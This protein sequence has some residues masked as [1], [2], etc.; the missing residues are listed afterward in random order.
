MDGGGA[1]IG[2]TAMAAARYLHLFG[3]ASVG[4]GVSCSSKKPGWA[5]VMSWAVRR[6]V[7]RTISANTASTVPARKRNRGV[8]ASTHPTAAG[9]NHLRGESDKL[10]LAYG[11]RR[12]AHRGA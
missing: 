5:L 12:D 4:R 10:A 9:Q 11:E 8:A 7:F 2:L 1:F 6:S 3:S